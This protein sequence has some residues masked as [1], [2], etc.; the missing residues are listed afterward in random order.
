MIR[1]TFSIDTWYAG[2]RDD[3]CGVFEDGGEWYA[4][5]VRGWEIIGGGPFGEREDAMTWAEG[6]WKRSRAEA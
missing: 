5:V 3:G 2:T 1:W 4:N 6:E